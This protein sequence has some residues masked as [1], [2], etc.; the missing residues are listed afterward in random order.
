MQGQNTHA[1]GDGDKK[2]WSWRK[3]GTM[4]V[5]RAGKVFWGGNRPPSSLLV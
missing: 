3:R 2:G 5:A 1:L 4:T